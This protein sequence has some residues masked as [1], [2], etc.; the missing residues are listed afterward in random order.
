[1]DKVYEMPEIPKRNSND[2]FDINSIIE[3]I[4]K[5]NIQRFEKIASKE[6]DR[7]KEI[8]DRL[9]KIHGYDEK[10]TDR[11]VIE[12]HEIRNEIIEK[13]RKKQLRSDIK[14]QLIEDGLIFNKRKSGET[15]RESVPQEVA[16]RIWNRDGGRCVKC[17]SNEKLEFDHIIP[18]SKGGSNTYRN[19]QLLCEKCNREK[20]D[21]IG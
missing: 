18:F 15:K 1:M 6:I 10:L 8:S 16:D 12:I 3:N 11:E 21:K 7:R 9:R 13:E 5:S 2:K 4:R 19:L 14:N 17:G 20:S